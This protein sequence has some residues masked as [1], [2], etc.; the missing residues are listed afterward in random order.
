[1][2]ADLV[3]AVSLTISTLWML[4]T[5]NWFHGTVSPCK[6]YQ[7]GI[8]SCLYFWGQS[9]DIVMTFAM[10]VDRLVAVLAPFWYRDKSSKVNVIVMAI[11]LV[12][13]TIIAFLGFNYKDAMQ[14]DP[15]S[16]GNLGG[17]EPAF[18]A[19]YNFGFGIAAGTTCVVYALI[20]IMVRV[21]KTMQVGP[22]GSIHKRQRAATKLALSLMASYIVSLLAGFG[23]YC[24]SL[25]FRLG[26]LGHE[27]SAI[28]LRRSA[29]GSK[30]AA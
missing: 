16:H 8:L 5:D 15:N 18:Q 29:V 25:L 23:Y 9:V 6:N 11:R 1:M 10:G 28:L 19:P 2:A 26:R 30:S 13:S 4:M 12:L 22:V 21:R 24:R 7:C 17:V 27:V 3:M 20:P 14:V